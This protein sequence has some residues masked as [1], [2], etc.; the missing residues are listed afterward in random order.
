MS[1]LLK[2][3]GNLYY[4]IVGNI[5]TLLL[6]NRKYL[7]GELFK[8]SGNGYRYICRSAPSQL[9]RRINV[10]VPWPV[11][12]RMNVSGWRNIS[13]DP[14]DMHIFQMSGVYFQALDA[15]ITIGKGI[16]IAPNVGIITTNHDFNDLGRHTK[17][18]AVIIGENCWLGMNS[19]ILP[20]VK[21]GSRTIVGA[22]SVVTKSFLEGNLI[23]AGNPAQVIRMLGDTTRDNNE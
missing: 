3:I 19:I 10:G 12:Q 7:S 13:F 1:R 18:E 21:L 17:G 9:F 15:P 4:Y 5:W 22:G 23:I 2:F 16:W 6:Y 8:F 11:S 14:D 20:G